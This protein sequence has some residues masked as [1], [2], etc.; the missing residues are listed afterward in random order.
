MTLNARVILA[1]WTSFSQAQN[2]QDLPHTLA[3]LEELRVLFPGCLGIEP[4]RVSICVD[5]ARDDVLDTVSDLGASDPDLEALFIHVASHGIPDGE[6]LYLATHRSRGHDDLYR[7]LA[8]DE[9]FEAVAMSPARSKVLFIDSCFSGT[10]VGLMSGSA[11]TEVQIPEF[12]FGGR[13]TGVF[14]LTSCSGTEVSYAPIGDQY[15]IFT[16]AIISA[17][18]GDETASL[19]MSPKE[20]ARQV[21][22]NVARLGAEHGRQYL[23]FLATRIAMTSA[24]SLCSATLLASPSF[25]MRIRKTIPAIFGFLSSMTNRN[26]FRSLTSS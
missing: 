15:T 9:L 18:G 12:R 6:Q 21:A 22:A 26:K 4:D 16:Q 3:G 20:L 13:R 19:V 2:F 14:V 11:P 1:A 24:T 8:M 5:K 7:S 10:A 25:E 23:Q 17:L